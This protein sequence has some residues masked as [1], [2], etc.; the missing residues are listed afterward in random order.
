MKTRREIIGTILVCIAGIILFSALP[1]V[2][3]RRG[4][5]AMGG[6]GRGHREDMITIH[7]LFADHEKIERKP[8]WPPRT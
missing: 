4:I 7:A 1:V 5:G 6:M 3:R 2:E 8:R